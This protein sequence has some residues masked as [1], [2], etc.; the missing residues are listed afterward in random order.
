MSLA[1]SARA[2][3]KIRVVHVITDLGMGGAEMMLYKLVSRMDPTRFETVVISLMDKE[4]DIAARLEGLGVTVYAVDMLR[5]RPSV[6]ALW[7]LRRLLRALQ[8]HVIQGWMY[9][10]NWAS[11]LGSSFCRKKIPVLWN[12]RHSPHDLKYERRLTAALIRAG[13]LYSIRTTKIVYN[14]H[15]SARL[16]TDLG[17][18]PDRTIVIPN[19]FDCELFRASERARQSTRQELN[20]EDQEVLIGLIGRY[21]PMKDHATFF[22]AAAMLARD[23][24]YVH[25]VLAGTHV[26]RSNEE[27]TKLVESSGLNGR[28]HLLGERADVA[29]LTAGLDIASSSSLYGEGFSNAIGEAM[30]CGVPCVVTDVGDSGWIVGETGKVVPPRD[31]K[32]LAMAWASLIESGR[33]ERLRLGAKARTR[34]VREF[35][36]DRVTRLY[37]NLY[38][39]TA[40]EHV[41]Q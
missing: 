9:H 28:T 29:E 34:V 32:A 25:F 13:S 38:E 23:Y 15:V 7:R 35:S 30:A 24:R 21:H 12:I 41:L 4:T 26:D 17:Y 19:G 6:V 36:L 10:G 3:M 27:L 5:G 16:H 11:S 20:V 40:S 2:G 31:P 33:E 22:K 14:S 18:S 39:Q 8:P 37:E 1:I